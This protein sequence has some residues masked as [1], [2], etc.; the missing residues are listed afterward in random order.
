MG[1]YTDLSIAGYPLIESQSWVLPEAM[2][3]FR[4][5]DK[6][7]TTR[8]FSERNHLVWGEL[9]SS[10]EDG[11][12]TAI[13]YVSSAGEVVD[14]LN[15]MGFTLRR[16]RKEFESLRQLRIE[17]LA[18]WEDD[19]GMFSEDRK[20]LETLSFEDYTEGFRQVMARGLQPAPF[21]DRKKEGLSQ[22]VKY[23]LPI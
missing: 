16:V 22:V 1:S 21:D 11:P 20:F 7:V 3:I 18:S 12:E 17:E 2:T 10:D 6:R 15:I 4:E 8:M 5:A 19:D 9:G 13:R 23:I 14:R